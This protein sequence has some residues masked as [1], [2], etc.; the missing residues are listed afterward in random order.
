MSLWQYQSET[1]GFLHRAVTLVCHL[2]VKFTDCFSSSN[3]CLFPPLRLVLR[4]VISC[5]SKSVGQ[6]F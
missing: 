3:R 6:D 4:I 2:P 1:D 5:W